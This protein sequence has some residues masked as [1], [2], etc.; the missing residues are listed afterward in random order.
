MNTLFRVFVSLLLIVILALQ[1]RLWGGP[2]SLAHL[3]GMREQVERRAAGNDRRRERNAVLRAE[4][5]DLRQGLEAV[6]DIARSELGLIREGETFFL[7]VEDR[8]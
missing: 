6:E 3:S 5:R 2:G 7:V 4:V 8:D 1:F